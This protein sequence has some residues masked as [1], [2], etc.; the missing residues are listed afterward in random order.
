MKDFAHNSLFSQRFEYPRDALMIP[1]NGTDTNGMTSRNKRTEMLL[2]FTDILFL[3][4][5]FIYTSIQTTVSSKQGKAIWVT[6]G[7]AESKSGEET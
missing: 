4:T 3:S 7:N 5:Y 2:A 1:R 6:I